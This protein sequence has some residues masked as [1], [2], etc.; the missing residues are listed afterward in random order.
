[1]EKDLL[2]LYIQGEATAGQKEAV[3]EWL[4]ADPAHMREFMAMRRA[5]DAIIWEERATDAVGKPEK[6]RVRRFARE[7]LKIA[8][9]L[10]VAFVAA[11]F[12]MPAV[13]APD[14]TC[15]T[16]HVPEGQR[17]EITLC[18]NT[19]VWLNAKS[20]LVFPSSF[21]GERSVELI[22][23]AY[24]NVTR[25]EQNPF[26][27][28]TAEHEVKVLG[29]EF[30]VK[31]YPERNLF[32]TS[33]I[34]GSVS[35][36]SLKTGQEMLLAPGH[37]ACSDDGRLSVSQFGNQGDFLWREGILAFEGETFSQILDKLTMY[38]D[39]NIE[40]KNR[41]VVMGGYTYTGKFW[42]KDGVE[43]VLKVLQFSHKFK[44][45]KDDLNNITIY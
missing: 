12:L 38:Y 29:T 15:Q 39:L 13:N 8:S 11:R 18:D 33:L 21:S 20:T 30:D 45:Q 10:L 31:S 28:R 42:I 40:I 17:A 16:I 34:K 44:Y 1:M 27:V 23:E 37:K 2:F 19:K 43:H 22:G 41:N 32:E 35:V 36:H 3:S 24:F 6:G 9:T 5:Y 25:N 4:D 7:F 14:I 26:I